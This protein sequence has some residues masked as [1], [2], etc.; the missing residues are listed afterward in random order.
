MSSA[1]L[2]SSRLVARRPLSQARV[3]GRNLRDMRIVGTN[4]RAVLFARPAT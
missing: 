1:I 3:R 2:V 4:P